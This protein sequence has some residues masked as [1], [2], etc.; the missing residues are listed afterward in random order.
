[1]RVRNQFIGYTNP[2][3]SFSEKYDTDRP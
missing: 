2:V 3:K 1:M